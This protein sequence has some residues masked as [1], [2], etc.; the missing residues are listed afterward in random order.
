MVIVWRITERCNLSCKFCGFDREVPRSRREADP[1]AV[2]SF[3]ATLA[4]YQHKTGDPVLVSW[5]GGEPLLWPPLAGL[6]RIFRADYQ[7]SVGTTT[8]GTC[9]GSP[10]VRSH[11]LEHYS[12]LTISVDGIGAVHDRLRGWPGGYSSLRRDVAALAEEKRKG[13][14]GPRLRANVLLMRETV[15]AFEQLCDELSGWGIE[16]IT[17]NQLGGNDR[18]EFYPAHRLLPEQVAWLSTN[19]PRLQSRLAA[20]GSRLLG[21]EAYLR[22]LQASAQNKRLAIDDCRPGER[23]LFINESGQVAPCSFAA[24]GYGIPMQEITSVAALHQLPARFSEQRCQ[25]RLPSCEDCHST[26]VFEKFLV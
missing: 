17:F 16:E 19:L 5:L 6:T 3:G 2:R 21:S 23:F 22:R 1:Q 4:D 26:Q 13:N 10:A 15:N 18:P 25:Q 7:L 8:N 9:L 11:L 12:E 24:S 14:R 20:H